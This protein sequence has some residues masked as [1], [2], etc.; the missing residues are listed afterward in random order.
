[1]TIN[2]QLLYQQID[3]MHIYNIEAVKFCILKEENLPFSSG[4]IFFQ[5]F[6]LFFNFNMNHSFNHLILI[7]HRKMDRSR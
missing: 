1:M 4:L 2:F 7:I 5:R 3:G 6:I